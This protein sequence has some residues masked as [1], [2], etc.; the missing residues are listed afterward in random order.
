[1]AKKKDSDTSSSSTSPTN[2]SGMEARSFDG[3]LQ[4]D[5]NDFHVKE[6]QWVHARNAINNSNIGDVGRMG[7]EPANRLCITVPTGYTIIGFIHLINDKWAVFSTNN[8]KSEIGYFEENICRYTKIVNADC[9]NFKTT[10]LIYGQS[11]E[12]FDCSYSLYWADGLNPDRYLN[13]GDIKYAPFAQPWPNV[14]WACTDKN[15]VPACGINNTPTPCFVC[16]PVLNSNGEPNLACDMT[17]L[18][19]L[20]KPICLQVFKGADGGELVNGSY[21]AVAAYVVNGLRVTDY[22]VPS[23]IQPLF[24]HTGVGGS[25]TIKVC[26][27]DTDMFDQFELVIVSVIAQQTVARRIGV[28]STKQKEIGI[29]IINVAQ[30]ETVPIKDIPVLNPIYDTSDSMA[31]VNDVLMRIAPTGKFQFNYQ[32]LANQISTK[33]VSVEYPEDY[34][35]KGGSNTGYMR[36]EVYSFFIRWVYKTGDKSVSFHIPGRPKRISTLAA[37]A[38]SPQAGNFPQGYELYSDGSVIDAP[39]GADDI[40]QDLGV[41]GPVNLLTGNSNPNPEIWQQWNTAVQEPSTSGFPYTLC[42]GGVVIAEGLM[43]YWE[44]SE[45]YPDDKPVIWNSSANGWSCLTPGNCTPPQWPYS[46]TQLQ[47]YDLC[48]KYIRHHRFPDNDLTAQTSHFRNN[49]TPASSLSNP[50]IK[51]IRVMGVKFENIRPPVDND[52]NLIPNIV[53]YE[54]LRGSRVGNRSVIAKGIINN[55]WEYDLGIRNASTPVVKGLY[56]NYPYNDLHPDQF[57]STTIT[58][59]D[60][61]DPGSNP[62]NAN[63]YTNVKSN[64]FSFHS[65][66]TN[67][68]N[69]YLSSIELKIYQEFSGRANMYFKYVDQ[70]PRQVFIKDFGLITALIAGVATALLSTT[71]RQS[72]ERTRRVNISN[73]PDTLYKCDMDFKYNL[74]LTGYTNGYVNINQTEKCDDEKEH[75]LAVQGNTDAQG[76]NN[77]M[78]TKEDNYFRGLLSGGLPGNINEVALRGKGYSN[79]NNSLISA[80]D[81]FL[82]DNYDINQNIGMMQ[83][84]K[85]TYE[86]GAADYIPTQ[87]YLFT[88]IAGLQGGNVS[89]F[90]YYLTEGA[91]VAWRAMYAF[92]SPQRHEL[93]TISH[94]LYNSWSQRIFGQR[95]RRIVNQAYIDNQMHD[96]TNQYR[97][98]N[99]YRGRYVALEINGTYASPTIATDETRNDTRLKDIVGSRASDYESPEVDF[100]RTSSTYYA[101]IKQRLRN[102][103]GQLDS[104]TQIPISC[105]INIC[106]PS[107]N[108]GGRNGNRT[109]PDG[110]EGLRLPPLSQCQNNLIE[111]GAFV[112][113]IS[114]DVT[115]A[116]AHWLRNAISQYWTNASVTIGGNTYTAAKNIGPGELIS[117]NTS[118]D[119]IQYFY[120]PHN[121]TVP[122]NVIGNNAQI[123]NFSFDILEFPDDPA[124][125][126]E[127]WL[128]DP[129]TITGQIVNTYTGGPT[130]FP[131]TVSIAGTT[132]SQGYFDRLV[133]R[134]TTTSSASPTRTT[135]KFKSVSN[136]VINN[137]PRY[138]NNGYAQK[139][140]N[141]WVFQ[142]DNIINDN[143]NN[144]VDGDLTQIRPDKYPNFNMYTGNGVSGAEIEVWENMPPALSPGSSAPNLSL[145]AYGTKA[146]NYITNIKCPTRITW[147][148]SMQAR[149]VP[150]YK[151]IDNCTNT[152]LQWSTDCIPAP[153]SS[154][155]GCLDAI[156]DYEAAF[157]FP[158][159]STQL[160]CLSSPPNPIIGNNCVA[161]GEIRM[162]LNRIT[163]NTLNGT[164][165]TPLIWIIDGQDQYGGAPGSPYYLNADPDTYSN[166]YYG[167][168]DY[169]TVTPLTVNSYLIDPA[170]LTSYDPSDKFVIVMQTEHC[171]FIMDNVNITLDT[172]AEYPPISITNVCMDIEE[173]SPAIYGCTDP[174]A[175]NYDSNATADNGCCQQYA[176]VRSNAPAGTINAVDNYS[177]GPF[178]NN[179]NAYVHD[180]ALCV[181]NNPTNPITVNFNSNT[182]VGYCFWP[183]N[184]Q[185]GIQFTGAGTS[186]CP[187]VTSF[188]SYPLFGGDIYVNRY[189]EKNSFFYF[190]DWMYQQ[191]DRTEWDYLK[192]RMMPYPAFWYNSEAISLT[193]MVQSWIQFL[194]NPLSWISGGASNLLYPSKYHVLDRPNSQFGLAIKLGYIYLFNSGV[195]DFFVESEYNLAL[196]D[197]GDLVEERHYQALGPDSYT[198]IYEMF[199]SG[200]IRVGNYYKYDTSLSVSKT[201]YEYTPWST[202][203]PPYYD[204]DVAET[205][206]KYIPQM[207][208]YSLPATNAMVRD[209]WRIF[210]TDNSYIFKS[211]ITTVKSIYKSGILILFDSDVPLMFQG[212]DQLETQLSTGLVIGNGGLFTQPSQ[213][214]MNA[215]QVYQYGSC[216]NKLSVVNT[217]VGVF[218]VSVEQGKIFQFSSGLEEISLVNLK[219]WLAQFMPFQLLKY[220]PNYQLADNPVAGIGVQTVYD[221]TNM[222]LYFCKKDWKPKLDTTG[223]PFVKYDKDNNQFYTE[224]LNQNNGVKTRVNVE[225]GN[226]RYFESASWTIS[227]DVKAQGWVSFHDWHPQLSTGTTNYFMTSKDNGV[228]MHNDRTDLYANYYG[229]DYPF[230]IEYLVNTIQEITTLRSIEYQLEVYQY[231][232]N[233]YDRFHVLDVNFDEAVIYNTEQ[234]SGRLRLFLTPKNNAPLLTQYPIVNNGSIDILYSKEENKYRF[235]QFWDATRNRSEFA[236]NNGLVNP[237]TNPAGLTYPPVPTL[238]VLGGDISGS[239]VSQPIW[240]TEANGYV[241]NLNTANLFYTQKVQFDRKRFRHYTTTVRLVRNVSKNNKML[242]SIANNKTLKSE[243]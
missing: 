37:N 130:V 111:D 195:R 59:N 163:S 136:V 194:T 101:A 211:K 69:P 161:R 66:E 183:C 110:Y 94:C 102:Q 141:Y 237:A 167:N 242:M 36:D 56:Q 190:N 96:F 114:D 1:M 6:S 125:K 217:P 3:E 58:K 84:P 201:Y 208:L 221:N 181:S 67:F 223:K 174:L 168:T 155:Q 123:N 78:E 86:W 204:P 65:P 243:R 187:T 80:Y 240:N 15:P 40:E 140:V 233:G 46:S 4:K 44:S 75:P 55:M 156:A 205:C 191:P 236:F 193:E 98:N 175:P 234:C 150:R 108:I 133:F 165:G 230:E 158:P 227:Y 35:I 118:T 137:T 119:L 220:F 23:N 30:D 206:W 147:D 173:T 115:G 16:V 82:E 199:K 124:I 222:L 159:T 209:N 153:Y 29:D 99:L 203:Y 225:L 50:N 9:L 71:G 212:T 149:T 51:H 197:F 126:L 32:P 2:S 176:C 179:L 7:N 152:A 107:N 171:H 64:L 24:S 90:L 77:T 219:W 232:Q 27:M 207:L 127:T 177:L 170:V 146:N 73:M 53:G 166:G 186:S 122:G 192:Y 213:A 138:Q 143:K 25:L 139:F 180:P 62:K 19:S 52:G 128:G 26:N 235:N 169:A 31:K 164:L 226:T 241:K 120:P 113:T 92:S 91:E 117:P 214:L 14:P 238:P 188:R 34:Y 142:Y 61:G 184:L 10:N 74:S 63:P 89:S 116:T 185:Y 17:R 49:A 215:D 72:T 97:V 38:P 231:A 228:W 5:A 172:C 109:L 218:W 157:G 18:E 148:V 54:I 60:S 239:S 189:T 33:W 21:F 39:N 145:C 88:Q 196:R 178:C 154:I 144:I 162:S 43:G 57:L 41:T 105:T 210:L 42:D 8:T 48:G 202:V 134:I 224:I 198:D 100:Q 70:H 121:N 20:F 28:Y 135:A 87:L 45:R 12:N 129:D 160:G 151:F 132:P 112:S 106:N 79:K 131:H 68:T 93:Q 81:Q 182:G 47:D 11:K 103:Y 229:V 216:Q 76:V 13:I 22:S 83:T 104:I 200:V 85:Y 95:R